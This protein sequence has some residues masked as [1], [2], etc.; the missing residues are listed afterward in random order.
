MVVLGPRQ[1]VGLPSPCIF[2][3]RAQLGTSARLLSGPRTC[4]RR[5]SSASIYCPDGCEETG[6]YLS[7]ELRTQSQL[8]PR[9][10]HR[11]L[12][13]P[14]PTCTPTASKIVSAL[15]NGPVLPVVSSAGADPPSQP[16][17][18]QGLDTRDVGDTGA[19]G[20]SW[21]MPTP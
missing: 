5:W 10:S 6:R 11:Q 1:V 14:T 3:G 18:A 19:A 8:P 2:L 12:R 15:V 13:P 4:S 16:G 17:L 9:P 7:S 20:Q 21:S